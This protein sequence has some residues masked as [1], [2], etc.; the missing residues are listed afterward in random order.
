MRSYRNNLF[1]IDTFYVSIG[2]NVCPFLLKKLVTDP[3]PMSLLFIMKTL[4]LRS[5]FIGIRFRRPRCGWRITLSLPLTFTKN[6]YVYIS[7][8]RFLVSAYHQHILWFALDTLLSCL[9]YLMKLIH[10]SIDIVHIIIE[11]KLF[12][13]SFDNDLNIVSITCC[14]GT[15]LPSLSKWF[16]CPIIIMTWSL[17][18]DPSTIFHELNALEAS[19]LSVRAWV[20]N[21]SLNN[22][23][24]CH[25]PTFM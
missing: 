17:I 14:S 21:V 8:L 12:I 19:Y 18:V 1:Q 9:Q 22:R 16:R 2:R 3:L 4:C 7:L 23:I 25:A 10:S 15:G 20:R 11:Y 24:N 6:S 13:Y 5:G